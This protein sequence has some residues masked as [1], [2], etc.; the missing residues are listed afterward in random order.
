[1]R[2]A[3][4]KIASYSEWMHVNKDSPYSRAAIEFAVTWAEKM[5]ASMSGFYPEPLENIA[6]ACSKDP[7]ARFGIT[8]FQYSCAV[9]FL[10]DVW[11][12]GEQLRRWHNSTAQ[13][14]TEGDKAN[15]TPGA[16]L[17]PA[18]LQITPR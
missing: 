11:L 4:G 2:L 10:V 12:Y 14:G 16:V 8:G 15:E 13:L 6:K 7:A 17:N 5:E 9:A 3:E 1:M 18:V